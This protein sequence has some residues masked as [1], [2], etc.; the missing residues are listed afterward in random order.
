MEISMEISPRTTNKL[1]YD[2]DIPLFEV[3]PKDFKSA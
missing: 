3:Y 2:P 1:T